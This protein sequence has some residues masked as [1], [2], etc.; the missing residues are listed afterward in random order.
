MSRLA[1]L[2]SPSWFWTRHPHT[3]SPKHW[4]TTALPKMFHS[5]YP[6]RLFFEMQPF[7]E[8]CALPSPRHEKTSAFPVLSRADPLTTLSYLKSWKL[9]R[10]YSLFKVTKFINDRPG[11]W[12]ISAGHAL[13][14]SF[15]FSDSNGLEVGGYTQRQIYPGVK[16]VAQPFLIAQVPWHLKLTDSRS[17]R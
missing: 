5:H 4:D 8:L 15:V 12:A 16:S 17:G 7:P 1:S 6:H 10:V 9:R 2:C 11:Y 14:A 13:S 3:Q